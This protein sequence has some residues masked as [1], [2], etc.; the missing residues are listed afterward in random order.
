M[1]AVSEWLKGLKLESYSDAF[2]EHGCDS[3]DKAG[4]LGS[5]DLDAMGITLQGHRNR[6]LKNLPRSETSDASADLFSDLDD[7]MAGLQTQLDGFDD[8]AVSH[9]V[10]VLQ[11]MPTDDL[12]NI[13]DDLWSFGQEGAA[14]DVATNDRPAAT[15]PVQVV[16]EAGDVSDVAAAAIPIAQPN[17]GHHLQRVPTYK[18]RSNSE[19]QVR[20]TDFSKRMSNSGQMSKHDLENMM[21]EE[22]IRLAMEKMAAAQLQKFVIKVHVSD[23]TS[24]TVAVTTNETAYEVIRKIVVK[25]R[26]EDDATWS[27]V[28]VCPSIHME[29]RL[30]D[31]MSV[32]EAYNAWPIM[33]D[34]LFE[35]RV[36]ETK[37]DLFTKAA[38]Y[39]PSSFKEDLEETKETSAKIEKAKRVLLQEYFS[40][41]NRLPDVKGWVQCRE[42]GKKWKKR[43]LVLRASGLYYSNKGESEASTDL[44]VLVKF[45]DIIFCHGLVDFAKVTKAPGPV[46]LCFR[47]NK[48]KQPVDLSQITALSF[49]DTDSMLPW[50]AGVRLAQHGA[51]LK[52]GFDETCR[53]FAEMDEMSQASKGVSAGKSV[54]FKASVKHKPINEANRRLIR[55]WQS[56]RASKKNPKVSAA[57]GVE[58]EVDDTPDENGIPPSMYEYSWFHGSVTREHTESLFKHLNYPSGAFLMRLS[59]SHP[60]DYVLSFCHNSGPCHFHVKTYAGGQ[61]YGIEGAKRFPSLVE[62][63]E[64]H[65]NV[66]DRLPIAL[67]LEVPRSSE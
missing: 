60:G 3:L 66:A 53:R 5:A 1:T 9:Q 30:E 54:R 45:D 55:Q 28:E 33:G 7:M 35:L 58:F 22:K 56:Q 48:R 6:I 41:T 13:L 52:D 15:P 17:S 11:S 67:Q 36:M 12:D 42:A 62:F 14:D 32:G 18:P 31:H 37:Y 16:E 50:E 20:L 21:K 25:N 29:R 19:L 51:K 8:Q 47:P 57:T 44:L 39:F 4:K 10:E 59:T 65:K 64:Y 61:G 23:G 34:F 26:L 40:S 49:A 43:F 38:K 2:T 63:V 24:K 46:C 27:L